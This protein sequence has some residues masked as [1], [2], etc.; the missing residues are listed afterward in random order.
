MAGSTEL[1]LAG[2]VAEG[3]DMR[4]VLEQRM[5]AGAN[6]IRTL[7]MHRLGNLNWHPGW[8]D[9]DGMVRRTLDLVGDMGLTC[10]WCVFSGTKEMMPERQQQVEWFE[11]EQEL[12]RP[13]AGFVILCLGNEI[14]HSGH[15]DIDPLVFSKPS[16]IIASRG[17]YTTDVYPK[18]PIWDVVF[19]GARRS[20]GPLDVDEFN[21][22]PFNNLNPYEFH[23]KWRHP[24][25]HVAVESVEPHAYGFAPEYARK[26]AQAGRLGPGA[27]FHVY[28][29]YLGQPG[30]G[31]WIPEVERCAEVFYSELL[32]G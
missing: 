17:S 5:N 4:P 26:M 14:N 2:R 11:K 32:R 13:Y 18:A 9:R 24:V 28:E 23:P 22:K 29:R 1:E 12:I 7:G 21:A 6:T 30:W 19:Y 8:P 25:P 15:Q 10:I 20:P 27:F 31:F 16:G 3:H